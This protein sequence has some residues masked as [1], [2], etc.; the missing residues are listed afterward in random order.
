ML[1]MNQ[2]GIVKILIMV[3]LAMFV[4]GS[5]AYKARSVSSPTTM[6]SSPSAATQSANIQASASAEV[7]N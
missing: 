7:N 1:L 5:I 4:L 6:Q 3:V 2:S